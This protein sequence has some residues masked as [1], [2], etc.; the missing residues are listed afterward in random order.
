MPGRPAAARSTT[1][2][3]SS[4]G[5]TESACTRIASSL[6][7]AERDRQRVEPVAQR[8]LVLGQVA[9]HDVA[10]QDAMPD[11]GISRLVAVER[12]AGADRRGQRLIPSASRTCG[13]NVC[14]RYQTSKIKS[15][16][17]TRPGPAHREA[18]SC[19]DVAA[20]TR[21]GRA[22]ARARRLLIARD[23]GGPERRCRA[24]CDTPPARRSS[25]APSAAARARA[26]TTRD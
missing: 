1:P 11:V 14:P 10:A 17:S 16:I 25:R 6:I 9:I 21:L 3:R 12:L 26:P 23:K 13:P 20:G 4:P 8:R 24:T 2:A 18:I 15:R 5:R 7:A 19:V 22:L